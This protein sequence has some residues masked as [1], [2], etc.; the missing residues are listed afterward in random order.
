MGIGSRIQVD[1]LD[2]NKDRTL[3]C[4]KREAGKYD[5]RYR[6]GGRSGWWEVG[7]FLAD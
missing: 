7:E 3:H 2:L 5:Y 1:G 4:N 6:E